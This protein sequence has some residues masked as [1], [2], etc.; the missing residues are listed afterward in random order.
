MNKNNKLSELPIE[1]IIRQKNLLK[2]VLIGFSIV[3][4]IAYS[5]LIYLMVTNKN[6]ILFT[7]IPLGFITLLPAVIRLSQI[8]A[9]I[10]L[11]NNS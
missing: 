10:K 1:E 6:Y 3:L 8:N 11:R 9:E 4:V 7:I 5:I 2:G